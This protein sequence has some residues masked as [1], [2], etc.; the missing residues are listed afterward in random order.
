MFEDQVHY[1]QLTQ[2][3]SHWQALRDEVMQ[4]LFAAHEMF[5][6]RADYGW[7]ILPLLVEPE[8]RGVFP[9]HT[10]ARARGYVPNLCAQVDRLNRLHAYA[11]SILNPGAEIKT[12]THSNL[13]ASASICLSGGEGAI[14]TVDDAIHTFTD[15]SMAIFDYRRSHTVTNAGTAPRVALIVAVDLAH[16]SGITVPE[17]TIF[18]SN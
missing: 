17:T 1:P 2:L 15:G 18:R 10:I 4:I 6:E 9:D 3:Q 14:I 7:F 16:E 11:L 13:F 8:D 12:H 5:D